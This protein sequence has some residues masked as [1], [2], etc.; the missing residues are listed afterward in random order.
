MDFW[1]NLHGNVKE[2]ELCCNAKLSTF[3][4]SSLPHLSFCRQNIAMNG[5]GK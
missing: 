4:D 1:I 3:L 5:Q 2:K